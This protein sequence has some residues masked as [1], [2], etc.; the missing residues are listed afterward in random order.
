LSSLISNEVTVIYVPKC[1]VSSP[2]IEHRDL[3]VPR[4]L[5]EIHKPTPKVNPEGLSYGFV[6]KVVQRGLEPQIV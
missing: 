1:N 5:A 6:A 2:G 4:Q 3:I